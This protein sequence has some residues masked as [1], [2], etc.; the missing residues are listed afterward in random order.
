MPPRGSSILL[1]MGVTVTVADTKTTTKHKEQR[2]NIKYFLHF[3]SVRTGGDDHGWESSRGPTPPLLFFLVAL[4]R[5]RCLGTVVGSGG[6]IM[7]R[8]WIIFSCRFLPVAGWPMVGWRIIIDLGRTERLFPRAFLLRPEKYFD[9]H[10]YLKHSLAFP[11]AGVHAV[12]IY[13]YSLHV[14]QQHSGKCVPPL[15]FPCIVLGLSVR[16][17]TV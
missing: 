17:Y 11:L 1:C 8:F 15:I 10:R 4:V 2:A 9:R 16:R 3:L 7:W 6:D 12:T 5:C 14:Q 13:I